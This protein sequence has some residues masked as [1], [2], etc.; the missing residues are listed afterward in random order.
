VA[1]ARIIGVIFIALTCQGASIVHVPFVGCESS[2]QVESV[3]APS[4]A[5]KVVRLGAST[6]RR[7]AYYKAEYSSGVLAP[8]GWYCFGATG[9]SSSEAFVTPQPVNKD[10]FF[11][12]AWRGFTGP[13]ILI[14][15]IGATTGSGRY[16]VAQVIARVFPK[17]KA[18]VEEVI[19]P[20]FD[21]AS[22]FPFGSYPND[23]LIYRGDRLVEY[24]TPPHSEGL[25]TMTLRL[26]ASDCPVDGVAILQGDTPDLLLL[27]VRLPAEMHDLTS[28]IIRQVEHDSAKRRPTR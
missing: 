16:T 22:D 14:E 8:R 3:P 15:D 19:G 5:D 1:A 2:G 6:A 7:L 11:S 12:P 23:K 26:Q 9:S 4:G 21:L 25:G 27:K 10:D 28:H 24:E 17:H 13:V 20:D 18:F